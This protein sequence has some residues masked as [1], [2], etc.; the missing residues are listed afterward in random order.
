[1]CL[2]SVGALGVCLRLP[3]KYRN[4]V[5]MN[6]YSQHL[7]TSPLLEGVEESVLVS[8]GPP[9]LPRALPTYSSLPP[10]AA[11]AWPFLQPKKAPPPL[12]QSHSALRGPCSA[13][14]GA[15]CIGVWILHEVVCHAVVCTWQ[16]VR[17]R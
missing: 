5:Y 2:P 10:P 7:M 16:W 15:A 11:A 14:S 12:L 17:R 8:R 1:M 6:V 9:S 3:P 4:L 13:G